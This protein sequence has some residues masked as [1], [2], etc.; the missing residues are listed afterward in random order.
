M[1]YYLVNM[2]MSMNKFIILK[3]LQKIICK[4]KQIVIGV[5]IG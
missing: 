2:Y 3:I 5:E 1:N 4:K